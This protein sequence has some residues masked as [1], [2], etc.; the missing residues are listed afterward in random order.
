MCAQNASSRHFWCIRQAGHQLT[1]D[2]LLGDD[3]LPGLG[4]TG[5]SPGVAVV[6]ATQDWG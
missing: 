5:D 4:Q 1:I 6:E 2:G 3:Q